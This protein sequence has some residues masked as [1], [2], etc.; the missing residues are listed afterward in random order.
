[1]EVVFISSVRSRTVIVAVLIG[2]VIVAGGCAAG[3]AIGGTTTDTIGVT[4]AAFPVDMTDE[5][6]RSVSSTWVNMLGLRQLDPAV[7]RRRLSEA[8]TL[9][10]WNKTVAVDLAGRYIAVDA[11]VSPRTPDEGPPTVEDGADALWLMALQVCRDRFAADAIDAGP[12]FND[13]SPQ[14]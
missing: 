4:T 7:W 6:L 9:G 5:A 1:M 2:V 10:V 13:K 3:S 12:P 14:K 11:S 8:C